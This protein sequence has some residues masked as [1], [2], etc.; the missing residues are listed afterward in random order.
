MDELYKMLQANKRE[1]LNYVRYY[2]DNLNIF[3]CYKKDGKLDW[4]TRSLDGVKME[5]QHNRYS[6]DHFN[7]KTIALVGSRFVNTPLC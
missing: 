6:M 5:G 3:S 7:R 4:F 1:G 2:S